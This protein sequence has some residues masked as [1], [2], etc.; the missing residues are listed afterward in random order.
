MPTNTPPPPSP[1]VLANL[2]AR[3]AWDNDVDDN[4]RE[5]LWAAADCIRACVAAKHR[6]SSKSEKL[7]A[8]LE[9]TLAYL[10]GLLSQ[11][12]SHRGGAA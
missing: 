11:R 2:C 12:G 5:L 1:G 10:N 9:R 4:S 8:E 3:R 7:E 6:E